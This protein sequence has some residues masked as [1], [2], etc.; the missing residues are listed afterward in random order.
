LSEEM[1][2][3]GDPPPHGKCY[4]GP[5]EGAQAFCAVCGYRPAATEQSCDHIRVSLGI[6]CASDE[7]AE[8]ALAEVWLEQLKSA[9]AQV[10][11]LLDEGRWPASE[12]HAL[13]ERALKA[14]EEDWRA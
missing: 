1:V 12:V 13:A 2:W 5:V 11:R 9:N 8:L 7:A 10:A 14:I 4:T 6:P 3:L